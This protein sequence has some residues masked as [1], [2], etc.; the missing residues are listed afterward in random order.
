MSDNFWNEVP[1]SVVVWLFLSLGVD[2]GRERE[3]PES[4][5][6]LSDSQFLGSG[7]LELYMISDT[8]MVTKETTYRADICKHQE[9]M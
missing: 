7:C 2:K 9:Y 8:T 3:L 6:L 1:D 4:E 5:L